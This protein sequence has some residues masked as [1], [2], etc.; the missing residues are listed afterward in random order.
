MENGKRQFLEFV[1]VL[2]SAFVPSGQRLFL[3]RKRRDFDL[4]WWVICRMQARSI[5]GSEGCRPCLVRAAADDA[6]QFWCSHTKERDH[7][8]VL[9]MGV[10]LFCSTEFR[11]TDVL[12]GCFSTDGTFSFAAEAAL[13]SRRE[14]IPAG[15]APSP[16]GPKVQVFVPHVREPTGNEAES[17]VRRQSG[18]R[19]VNFYT[20]CN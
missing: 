16:K 11:Q 17:F 3:L 14:N 18:F 13:A 6:V 2:L 1:C 4:I 8:H 15:I 10:E 5:R 7:A 12:L 9:E 20:S 19:L